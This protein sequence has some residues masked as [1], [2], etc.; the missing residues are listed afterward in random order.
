MFNTPYS[1]PVGSPAFVLNAGRALNARCNQEEPSIS[2]TGLGAVIA[3]SRQGWLI[4]LAKHA[5]P[6]PL[7]ILTTPTPPAQEVS[8]PSRADKP[9]KLAP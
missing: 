7:S 4:R 3:R 6:N 8:I 1:A 9:L 5:A 2:N